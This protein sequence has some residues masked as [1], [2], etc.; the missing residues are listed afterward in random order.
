MLGSTV[1]AE[2]LPQPAVAWHRVDLSDLPAA[3]RDVVASVEP[4]SVWQQRESASNGDTPWL[5][6]RRLPPADVLDGLV[7]S[8]DTTTV[9]TVDGSLVHHDVVEAQISGSY[10]AVSLPPGATLWSTSVDG[11]QVRPVEEAG[12]V[13]VPVGFRHDTRLRIE[14]VAVESQAVERGRSKIRLATPGIDVPVLS[15]EW[16]VLLPESARY[17]LDESV[18]DPAEV[19]P[20]TRLAG[21]NE[22]SVAGTA[23]YADDDSVLPG[24]TLTLTG[25]GVRR[26]QFSDVEGR[27]S[28]FGLEPGDYNLRGELE[29][30]IS[31]EMPLKVR[32]GRVTT[33]KVPLGNAVE[34][35]ITVTSESPT[36][37]A[38][39]FNERQMRR[40]R[41]ERV[42]L[43]GYAST[44]AF[45]RVEGAVTRGVKPLPVEIP[46]S[47]KLIRMAGAL[48]PVEIWA[49]VD[50]RKR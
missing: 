34:E 46:K 47:G 27:F 23:I 36:L 49:T 6:V 50:V 31:V 29:G 32:R 15:H 3:L 4:S 11:T 28:F 40:R 43:R 17:R 45:G 9:L 30:F 13:L 41:D 1:A 26:V 19:L 35:S 2:L 39:T 20:E 37:D 38:A 21:A 25:H 8:R 22:A 18:L 24:A 12:R 33:P 48:P 7:W 5:E 42:E 10:L 44:A 14:V 16:H